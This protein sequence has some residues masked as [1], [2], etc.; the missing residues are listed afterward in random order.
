MGG[1]VQGISYILLT[2]NTR[3]RSLY[4]KVI[5][6]FEYVFRPIRERAHDISLTLIEVNL[7]DTFL[8][9]RCIK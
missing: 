4:A 5:D 7:M 2:N 9:V 6:I 3:A 8:G 1:V